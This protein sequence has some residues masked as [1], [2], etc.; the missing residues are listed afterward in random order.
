MNARLCIGIGLTGALMLLSAATCLAAVCSVPSGQYPTIQSAVDD[1][2]CTEIV[3]AE[4]TFEESVTVGRDLTLRGASSA[5]SV[6][7][8]RLTAQGGA[9]EVEL[10]NLTI[11]ASAAGVAGT[12]TEALNVLSGAELNGRDVV[13]LNA[14]FDPFAVFAD[15]F[16]SGDTAAW[17][18]TVP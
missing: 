12:F 3:L 4:R 1:P 6:I 2:S 5:T 11:D 9:T 14:V 8:G 7:E 16:E 15:G 13:V 18:T 17:S 10:E